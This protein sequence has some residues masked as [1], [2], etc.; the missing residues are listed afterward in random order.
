MKNDEGAMQEQLRWAAFAAGLSIAACGW[1]GPVA[2]QSQGKTALRSGP[3]T[4]LGWAAFERKHE[5]PSQGT[6]G[7]HEAAHC[8]IG[9]RITLGRNC[10]EEM[11]PSGKV[12]MRQRSRRGMAG[13]SRR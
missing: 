4:E 12:P 7:H 11:T 5:E 10:W 9:R 13:H 8:R 3:G 6:L 1:A 2:S